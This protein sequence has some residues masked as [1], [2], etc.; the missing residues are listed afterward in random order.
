LEVAVKICVTVPTRGDHPELLEQLVIDSGVPRH[1]FIIVRTANV[2]TP[3]GVTVIDDFGGL[4][5]HRWWNTG[6][7]CAKERGADY[8]A[9]L[10]D[11]ISIEP[12]AIQELAAIAAKT[13]STIATPFKSRR[14]FKNRLPLR[15]V[16]IGSLWLLDLK[17]ELRPDENFHWWYG[18]DDLDIRARRDFN[19]IIT[20]PINFEHVHGGEATE[21][22]SEL[23]GFVRLDELYFKSKYPLPYFWRILDRKLGGI[24]RHR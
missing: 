20:M 1:E 23:E 9:V 14:R 12:G 15:P 13:G 22:S 2:S 17:T 24:L 18:D 7:A 11:D 5:I 8:V 10:N 4:N 6:I 21:S 16:L 3:D 19:G